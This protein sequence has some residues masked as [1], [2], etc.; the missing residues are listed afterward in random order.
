MGYL[1]SFLDILL[2]DDNCRT[3]VRHII[4]DCDFT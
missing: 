3:V 1:L 4:R 2:L